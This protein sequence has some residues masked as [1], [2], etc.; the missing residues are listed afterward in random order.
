MTT[1]TLTI[2]DVKTTLSHMPFLLEEFVEDSDTTRSYDVDGDSSTIN[3]MLSEEKMT[4]TIS[5]IATIVSSIVPYYM[6][7][8]DNYSTTRDPSTIDVPRSLQTEYW[9]TLFRDALATETNAMLLDSHNKLKYCYLSD[10]HVLNRSILKNLLTN[11]L[12]DE[13]ETALYF[14]ESDESTEALTE[15]FTEK[16]SGIYA[17]LN[18][19]PTQAGFISDWLD[20]MY[21]SG[22]LEYAARLREESLYKIQD[23]KAELLR[24]KFAGSQS[25]YQIVLSAINRR[26]TFAAAIPLK[27][28]TQDSSFTD[29]RYIRALD[30]PGVTTLLSTTVI[31]P[32]T[33]FADSIPARTIIPL[34]YTSASYSAESFASDPSQYL[35]RASASI[36]WDNL[37]GVLDPSLVMTKSSTL[38]SGYYLDGEFSDDSA[39]ALDNNTPL[40]DLTYISASFFDLQADQT[41]Y[42]ENSLQNTLGEEY[43]YITYTI[44]GGSSLSLMDIPWLEYTEAVLDGKT[45]VQEAV[46]TGV[47]V[48]RLVSATSDQI[49]ENF[50]TITFAEEASDS[51]D[52]QLSS[53]TSDCKYAYLWNVTVV[54]NARTFTTTTSKHV[55]S[56]ILLQVDESTLSSE[57]IATADAH[58]S[59]SMFTA[60]STGLFPFAYQELSSAT[61]LSMQLAL[62]NEQDGY[63]RDD[64]YEE[65]YTKAYFL[66]TPYENIAIA[67]QYL[68]T[69]LLVLL[70]KQTEDGNAVWFTKP[71]SDRA[72]KH[73]IYGYSRENMDTGDT[74]WFW[75]EPLRLYPKSIATIGSLHPDWMDLILY[76]NPYLNFTTK[77]A[78]PLRGKDIYYRALQPTSEATTTAETIPDSW[79]YLDATAPTTDAALMNLNVVHGR[80]L[81][82]NEQGVADTRASYLTKIRPDLSGYSSFDEALGLESLQIWG[83]NRALWGDEYAADPLDDWDNDSV[84]STV[85]TDSLGIPALK[86]VA[87]GK[88]FTAGSAR[89][90]YYYLQPIGGNTANWVWNDTGATGMT[91]CIDLV[92]DDPDSVGEDFYFCSQHGESS[93]AVN[94][95]FDFYYT[96]G[97]VL[98]FSVYPLGNESVALTTTLAAEFI[99]DRQ[100]QLAASYHY[101]I[102]S[103]VT[104]KLNITQTLVADRSVASQYYVAVLADGVY[105]L[106]TS[107][108]AFAVGT[109]ITTI[110]ETDFATL[111]PGLQL[112]ELVK[113]NDESNNSLGAIYLYN[114]ALGDPLLGGYNCLLGTVYD[115]RLYARG[116][117]RAETI[118]VCAGTRRELYSYSPS[119]YKLSYQ[120]YSD[121]GVL[122]QPVLSDDDV[123]S[124]DAI[125]VFRRSV[126]DSILTDLYPASIE[127]MDETHEL[128]TSDYGDPL[129]DRDVYDEEEDYQSGVIE[130]LL[131]PAYE[132]QTGV[133]L[134]DAASLYYRGSRVEDITG[135]LFSFVQTTMYPIRYE[136]EPLT[137]G[138]SLR[139]SATEDAIKQF[140][141][142]RDADTMYPTEAAVYAEIPSVPSGDSLEYTADFGLNLEL[143]STVLAASPMYHGTNISVQYRDDSFVVKHKLVQQP[144]AGGTA[145]LNAI[146]LPLNIAPQSTADEADN[147]WAAHISG[148]AINNVSL[149]SAVSKFL[150][151]RSYYNELQIPY[152][153]TDSDGSIMY[154]S[155]WDALRV[156]KEGE[157]YLTCKFPVQFLPQAPT[158]TSRY[159]TT[160]LASRL[161]I[162]V[163]GAPTYYTEDSMLPLVKWRQDNIGST[164]KSGALYSPEDNRS[165]PH[166]TINIDLFCMTRGL[167]VEPQWTWEKVASNWDDTVDSLAD[168]SSN[169]V[170]SSGV[171]G[172][173]T[174]TY[175]APFFISGED[176]TATA[177]MVEIAIGN[178]SYGEESLLAET[179]AGIH[180]LQLLSSNS[181]RILF[182]FTTNITELSYCST[183]F[184]DTSTTSDLL[185]DEE[186]AAYPTELIDLLTS[187]SD[188]QALALRK[189]MYTSAY[190]WSAVVDDYELT[191]TTTGYFVQ[192]DNTFADPSD[193]GE[194]A[195]GN[196]YSSSSSENRLLLYASDRASFFNLAYFPYRA[197]STLAGVIPPAMFG[198]RISSKGVPLQ[199][200]PTRSRTGNSDIILSTPSTYVQEQSILSTYLQ[201]KVTELTAAISSLRSNSVDVVASFEELAP[202]FFD[203]PSLLTTVDLPAGDYSLVSTT[204]PTTTL[205]LQ[206]SGVELEWTKL[207][208]NSM[209]HYTVMGDSTYFSGMLQTTSYSYDTDLAAEVFGFTATGTSKTLTYSSDTIA[210]GTYQFQVKCKAAVAATLTVIFKSSTQSQSLTAKT[211][212]AGEWLA[213]D[214]EV[215]LSFTATSIL[216]IYTG[217]FSTSS[218]QMHDLQMQAYDTVGH[219]HYIGLSDVLAISSLTSGSLQLSI[220]TYSYVAVKLDDVKYAIQFYNTTLVDNIQANYADKLAA[221]IS[222]NL[223][224]EDSSTAEQ[225]LRLPWKR[226]MRF[227]ESDPSSLQFF[228]YRRKTVAS[229]VSEVVDE[230]SDDDGLLY[231]DNTSDDVTDHAVRFVS[232]DNAIEFMGEKGLQ[233]NTDRFEAI[234]N[235]SLQLTTNALAV[236]AEHFSA[237]SGCV[238]PQKFIDGVSSPV[239]VTNIQ[240]IH[241][242]AD[243]ATTVLYE[244]EYLP[245]IYDESKHHLSM[246]FLIRTN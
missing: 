175:T 226:Q 142:Y 35:R 136:D 93:S 162:V 45:R 97:H 15:I 213:I 189:V 101:A 159:A 71:E 62:S 17:Q 73:V 108:S 134:D 83:D 212:I 224:S 112:G 78:S 63:I 180:T 199:P 187:T 179:E 149:S 87:G 12:L 60:G 146:L 121:T 147:D 111:L 150:L 152:P 171:V 44:S 228:Q 160:Y 221:F 178:T 144:S 85:Y 197:E 106:S 241:R 216:F 125:R 36:T 131:V 145:Q 194:L 31:D 184:T 242:E 16:L 173:L 39:V 72:L 81:Y 43:P 117:T 237:I 167:G 100:A 169:V 244:L 225:A 48:S 86:F 56:C 30:I 114:R 28:A 66:F 82:S 172:Y 67:K 52:E 138:V 217:T 37:Q 68:N 181:Y 192:S 214:E 22:Q 10:E 133:S 196:P 154:T 64:L 148:F 1:T 219:S 33:A 174:R 34:Y 198:S 118:Y 69:P 211:L 141:A 135:A 151:A 122:K 183:F 236:T 127:E 137:S 26:G 80:K 113:Q 88:A 38:D 96:T 50:V 126:W 200:L 158:T 231:A 55:V 234:C 227:L 92:V 95:A 59:Y 168:G 130:Q 132:T 4:A 223:L 201:A 57:A 42:H 193:S 79:P 232:T 182:D 156:L 2:D 161:K 139:Y 5:S 245:I 89:D 11:D 235:S 3:P 61:I 84:R 99:L 205:P 9:T 233:L 29:D 27:T 6:A 46:A 186:I 240:L 204:I 107:T 153:Y 24:R 177:D 218:I 170:I 120:Y 243:E 49:E 94:A 8:S 203:Y 202:I 54:Y 176:G 91:F 7:S 74:E 41:L 76:V 129:A 188:T 140:K 238:S 185:S 124:V 47:Q 206:G 155:R 53:Y 65:E 20:S 98:T 210:S 105:T 70:A 208:G 102:D 103:V 195:L 75:S 58:A 13:T 157:Y 116:C 115:T 123:T 77:S 222:A 110:S 14:D 215:E 230:L 19:T 165:F 220:P 104:T 51:F 119:L 239:V 190:D 209:L 109:T 40:Y 191:S 246:N 143:P 128:Y 166:R 90:S 229:V 25:L 163:S 164:L 21:F 18:Y 23:V 32:L 207:R